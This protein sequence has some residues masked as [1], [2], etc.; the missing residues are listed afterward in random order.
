MKTN[1]LLLLSVLLV[2]CA[3]E[4]TN[5]QPSTLEQDLQ[6][7]WQLISQSIITEDSVIRDFTGDLEGI[8]IINNSHFTFF[9]HDKDSLNRYSSGAGQYVLE[10]NRYVEFLEYCS[11]REWEMHK[12][13]FEVEIRN[14]TL[15]QSGVEKLPEVGV[16][17]TLVEVYVR[18]KAENRRVPILGEIEAKN[19]LWF[20]E[21][22]TASIEGVAK[23]KGRDG[24][25]HFGEQFAIELMPYS[26]YTEER[27]D[28]IYGNSQAGSVY[29]QDGIPSF[30]PD[31]AIYHKTIKTYCKD[32]GSFELNDLPKGEYFVIAFM[33]WEDEGLKGGGVMKRIELIRDQKQKI[34]MF[35][36]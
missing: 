4:K 1:S 19:L 14:D 17:R 24:E 11:A 31:P 16:D 3:I 9:Q 2:S 13:E 27:L 6:G 12:F 30:I 8:K 29:V 7:T 5:E 23:F 32:D 34:K 20:D 33:L 18:S 15:I 26:R 21:K 36:Y 22:G 10:G 35:N 28:R 25:I